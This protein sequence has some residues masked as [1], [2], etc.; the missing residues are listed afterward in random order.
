MRLANEKELDD[1]IECLEKF[2]LA[3]DHISDEALTDSGEIICDGPALL[4]LREA[5][6]ALDKSLLEP[7]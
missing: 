6:R 5:L 3:H 4:K 7:E 1:F 2:V